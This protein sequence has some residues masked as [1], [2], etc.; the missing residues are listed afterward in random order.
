MRSES[1]HCDYFNTSDLGENIEH[2][3]RRAF[4]L[5][6]VTRPTRAHSNEAQGRTFLLICIHMTYDYDSPD[7]S[8]K[9]ETNV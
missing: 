3:T 5:R 9:D 4:Q 8:V 2:A 1:D 7:E 6:R